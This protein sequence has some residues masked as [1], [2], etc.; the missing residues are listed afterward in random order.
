[1]LYLELC[2]F[3]HLHKL[4]YIN[5]L[6]GNIQSFHT[7]TQKKNE[8]RKK[9]QKTR[10]SQLVLSKYGINLCSM[11]GWL[12]VLLICVELLNVTVEPFFS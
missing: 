12:F 3:K 6:L 7:H 10:G 2:L 4:L 1:M 9:I 8:N 5:T 11:I